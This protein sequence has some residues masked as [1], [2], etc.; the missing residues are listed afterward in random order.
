MSDKVVVIFYVFLVFATIE[1]KMINIT[2]TSGVVLLTKTA[3]DLTV[4]NIKISITK[5][6]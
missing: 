5:M 2:M 3:D 4:I 1:I 6:I